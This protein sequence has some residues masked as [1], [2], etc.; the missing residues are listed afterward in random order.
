MVRVGKLS[1]WSVGGKNYFTSCT[2]FFVIVRVPLFMLT[3]CLVV[4]TLAITSYGISS[5]EYDTDSTLLKVAKD[6]LAQ[7]SQVFLSVVLLSLS[8]SVDVLRVR[9]QFSINKCISGSTSVKF[10]YCC[11]E[12]R[13]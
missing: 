1:V 8:L 12:S 10:A 3:R 2:S 4:Y 6:R 13:R 11:R 5:S 7:V 9:F